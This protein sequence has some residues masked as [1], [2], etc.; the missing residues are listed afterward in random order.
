MI[1]ITPASV[2][3]RQKEFTGVDEF[4]VSSEQ[5]HHVS[6]QGFQRNNSTTESGDG[7]ASLDVKDKDTED[8]PA[9]SD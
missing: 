6:S 5:W 9:S 1:M 7:Y 3:T 4:G 8:I 2:L